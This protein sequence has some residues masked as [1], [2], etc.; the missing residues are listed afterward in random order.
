MA[1]SPTIIVLGATGTQGGAVSRHLG[2]QG[3]FRIIAITRDPGTPKAGKAAALPQVEL[4]RCDAD[5]SDELEGVFSAYAPLHGVFSVQTND[6]TKEGCAKEVAQGKRVVDLCKKYAVKHLVYSTVARLLPAELPD[7][8]T[9][10]EIEAH[11]RASEAPFT[12]LRPTF[13]VENFFADGFAAASGAAVGYPGF[14]STNPVEQ[15]YIYIDDLGMIAARIFAEGEA[16]V[17]RTL[18]LAGDSLTPAQLVATFAEHNGRPMSALETPADAFGLELIPLFA[19]MRD[20]IWDEVDI[21]ALRKE[22]PSLHTVEGA[23]KHSGYRP[24]QSL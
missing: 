6:Y 4:V 8:A 14:K 11:L 1:T 18:E 15:K 23:L 17:G 24:P 2:S 9:K 7:V 16:W 19:A 13:F 12:V 5:S 21:E 10:I 22:F 3:G 20:G